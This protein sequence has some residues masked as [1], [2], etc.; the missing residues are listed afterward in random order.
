MVI[1]DYVDAD[2]S[3]NKFGQGA[4]LGQ[5]FVEAKNAESAAVKSGSVLNLRYDTSGKLEA[6]IDAAGLDS[7]PRTVGVAVGV[8]A[9]SDGK[10]SE[11]IPAGD[12]GIFQI[13][14]YCNLVR[15]S[16]TTAS[17]KDLNIAKV[18][19]ALP[20]SSRTV[21]TFGRAIGDETEVDSGTEYTVAAQLYGLPVV[22]AE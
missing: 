12:I 2:G 15:A 20:A 3:I 4:P 11:T 17:N 6:F 10:F 22:L 16:A 19:F 14:G 7:V 21:A 1:A 8:K 18:A 9:E 13:S 5:E